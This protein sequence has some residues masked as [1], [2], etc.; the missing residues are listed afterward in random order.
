M[1]DFKARYH[2]MWVKYIKRAI[3]LASDRDSVTERHVKDIENGRV[4]TPKK[5]VQQIWAKMGLETG[6]DETLKRS[7]ARNCV[8]CMED[9]YCQWVNA[10]DDIKKIPTFSSF[11]IG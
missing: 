6:V 4:R 11:R 10:C 7:L 2:H 8:G 9:Q 5:L 3:C 1:D